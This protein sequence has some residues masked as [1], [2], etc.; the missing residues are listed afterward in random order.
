MFGN[1]DTNCWIPLLVSEIA[2][3]VAAAGELTLTRI[4]DNPTMKAAACSGLRVAAEGLSGMRMLL[5]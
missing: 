3:G 4:S 2:M 5:L 1:G